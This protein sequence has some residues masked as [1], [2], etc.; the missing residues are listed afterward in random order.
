MIVYRVFAPALLIVVW[1]LGWLR[2]LARSSV[3]KDPELL[4]LRH[5]VTVLRRTN[6]KPRLDGASRAILV[7]LT[8]LLPKALRG[9]RLVTPSTLLR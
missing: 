1:L 5:E 8:P 3:S 7:A 9:H 4:V 2:L 6:P